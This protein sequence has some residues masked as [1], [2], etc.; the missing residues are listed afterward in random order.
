M[1]RRLYT[2]IMCCQRLTNVQRSK[3]CFAQDRSTYA[4]IQAKQPNCHTIKWKTIDIA[5]Y[6]LFFR[7]NKFDKSSYCLQIHCF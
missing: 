5:I 4:V 3:N 1:L 6:F 7:Y 2:R